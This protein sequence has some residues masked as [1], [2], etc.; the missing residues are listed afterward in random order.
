METSIAICSVVAVFYSLKWLL[1]G[2]SATF[3]LVTGFLCGL[4]ILSRV[5]AIVLLGCVSVVLLTKRVNTNETR[6]ERSWT[7]LRQLAGIWIGSIL[8]LLPWLWF[9][10][11]HGKSPIPES[12][13]AVRILT[14]IGE[15]LP[16]YSVAESLWHQPALFLPFYGEQLLQFTAAWARQSPVL[17]PIALPLYVLDASLLGPVLLA[18]VALCGGIG[19]II[20]AVRDG[21]DLQRT[22]SVV[23]VLYAAGMTLAYA[24]VV[25]G[26][27]FYD[28][29]GAVLAVLF[30]A[31]TLSVFYRAVWR[32]CRTGNSFLRRW[33]RRL[34]GRAA[35]AYCVA[36]L[37]SFIALPIGGGYR[38]L[39]S[40]PSVVPDDGFYRSVQ[41][42]NEH[43]RSSSRVGVFQAGLIGYYAEPLVIN[44][45]GKVNADAQSAL[46]NM[47]MWEYVCRERIE[48]VADWPSQIDNLEGRSSSVGWQDNNLALL[49]QVQSDIGSTIKIYRVNRANCPQD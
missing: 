4:A 32:R 48:Y 25:L 5:D 35:F 41:W 2:S 3:G 24:T 49:H 18:M 10:S 42:L 13:S 15:G 12:G 34:E 22:V 1:A 43:V 8:P 7:H 16:L 38:W 9:T 30:S 29:Y 26:G 19:L 6:G 21:S 37:A 39:I 45:D 31:L 44:L 17:L 46:V 11:A 23:W 28:R 14:L 20:F 47:R 36:I 40:G 33:I 27:W